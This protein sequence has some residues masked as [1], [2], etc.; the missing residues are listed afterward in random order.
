MTDNLESGQA[1][2]SDE[3]VVSQGADDKQAST[4]DADKMLELVMPA[5]ERTIERKLQS[6][7]D[8]RFSEMERFQN[9][10]APVLERIKDKLSPEDYKEV[11]RDLRLEALE[12]RITPPE[13]G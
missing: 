13:I 12:K 2:G 5:L 9:E 4:F 3:P 7:K 10:Y 11:E 8:K 6:T 1:A